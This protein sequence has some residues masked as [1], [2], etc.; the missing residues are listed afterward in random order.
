M[1]THSIKKIR[2]AIDIE[3][4]RN[5]KENLKIQ[6][7]KKRLNEKYEKDNIVSMN[8]ECNYFI[9]CTFKDI[10][11]SKCNLQNSIFKT[12]VFENVVFNNCNLK[13][14][15]FINVNFT[16]CEFINSTLEDA[17]FRNNNLEK[18]EIKECD[19]KGTKIVETYINKLKFS[20]KNTI[21]LGED[22]FID[23]IINNKDYKEIS[24]IYREIGKKFEG[25]NLLDYASEYYYLSKCA[26][27]KTLKGYGKIKSAIFWMLCGYGERPTYAL[28]TSLEIIIIFSILYMVTGLSING[29][30]VTYAEDVL[31]NFSKSLYFSVVT[32]TTVGYGD[33]TPLGLSV[34]LS[35]IEM[36]L[37]VTMVGVWTA[38]LARKIIR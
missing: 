22:T 19:L 29:E 33:I 8:M 38:T 30:Y 21:D 17:I 9:E 11:I 7:N 1:Q 34:L 10:E 5:I 2:H 23:R 35:A 37:G 15:I 4:E 13:A 20:D 25:N 12:C 16:D 6:K 31:S 27:H 3:I 36:F 26:K 28:I 18:V 24:R 14:A 32:F